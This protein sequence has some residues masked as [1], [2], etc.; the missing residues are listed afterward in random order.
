MREKGYEIELYKTDI[1]YALETALGFLDLYVNS[2]YEKP[3]PED[4]W[5]LLREFGWEV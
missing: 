1:N 2:D 3:D 4:V 5:D